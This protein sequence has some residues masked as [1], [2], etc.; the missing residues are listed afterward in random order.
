MWAQLITAPL[1]PG[2]D[3]AAAADVL[4]TFEQPGSGL[5]REIF[6]QDQKNPNVGYV[7]T[8]FESEEQ[9]REREQ[10]GRSEG[11]QAM[12]ELMAKILAGPPEF[13]D[14]TVVAEWT[15]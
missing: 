3:L 15:P 13:V 1:K 11:H 2:T 6:M 7:L 8:L 10:A 5:I 4:K 14:L 12:G 9:A